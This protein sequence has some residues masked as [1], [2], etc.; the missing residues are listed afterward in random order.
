MTRDFKQSDGSGKGSN[1]GLFWMLS[2]IIIGL[3]SGFGLYYF[4]NWK[5]SAE[6]PRADSRIQNQDTHTQRTDKPIIAPDQTKPVDVA[7]KSAEQEEKPKRINF[8]Y[9]ALLPNLELDVKIKPQE[10]INQNDAQATAPAKGDYM[11]QLASL[12]QISR[13]EK[14]RNDLIR[15]GINSTIQETKVKGAT[16]YR[17]LAGPV[18]SQAELDSLHEQVRSLGY[19]PIEIK[20]K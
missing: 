6:M 13:G 2:G 18:S 5:P 19:K 4:T 12:K 16:W 8:S 15:R 20:I 3:L 1:A 7:S 11:L 9:H 10:P 17:L 14:A